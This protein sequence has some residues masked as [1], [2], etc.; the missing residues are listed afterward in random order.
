MVGALFEVELEPEAF[1]V[2]ENGAKPA[3]YL[4]SPTATLMLPQ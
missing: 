3:K 2:I 1:A 4:P